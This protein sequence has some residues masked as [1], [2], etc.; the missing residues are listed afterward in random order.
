MR[1]T[2]AIVVWR[3][4]VEEAG[5]DWRRD[6]PHVGS[7]LSLASIETSQQLQGSLA[8]HSKR[9]LTYTQRSEVQERDWRMA[10]QYAAPASTKNEDPHDNE[11]TQ[12]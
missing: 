6:H 2:Y 9:E 4:D 8:G 12:R 7:V 3:K 1:Q 10:C 5:R 11:P